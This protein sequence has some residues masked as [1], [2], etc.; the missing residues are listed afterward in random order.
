MD[1]RRFDSLV[2][3]LAAGT[4]RRRM[5]KGMLGLGGAAI[6]GAPGASDHADAARRGFSGPRFPTPCVPNCAGSNCGSDGC[7]GT[8][9]QC[10]P[11]GAICFEGL[12]FGLCDPSEG[13][14][15]CSGCLC[16]AVNNVCVFDQPVG[17]NCAEAGCPA[18]SFCDQSDVCRTACGCGS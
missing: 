13:L 10:A 14:P 9:G 16:D 6:V 15:C 8:C 17:T 3:S 12:C 4:S 18:G 1:D 7:G 2:R 11:V 5:L